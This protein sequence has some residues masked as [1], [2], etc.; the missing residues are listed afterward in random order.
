MVD[1]VKIIFF[2]GVVKE[3]L[4]GVIIE[5]IV[6]F[7]SLGLKKKVVVG[8][9]NDEMIDFVILIEEDGVVFIIIL[10]FEDG[11]YILCYLIVY[12]LV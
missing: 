4:K 10:D 1:V 11:L 5:E 7:I 9:L 12:F 2:D 3:F 8:K 6:V